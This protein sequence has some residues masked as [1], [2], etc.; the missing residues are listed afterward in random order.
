MDIFKVRG[1]RKIQGEIVLQGAKNSALPILAAC[2]AVKGECIIHNCPKLSD[3][4]AAIEILKHLG[5]RIDR[6]D[7]TICVNSLN[8]SRCDIPQNLMHKMRSSIIFLGPLLSRC[9]KASIYAPG[10]CE[11]GMRPIDLHLTAMQ[12]LGAEIMEEHGIINFECTCL[13][14]SKIVLSFPSVGATENIII[15][16]A[17]A[18]GTTQIINA[19]REPEIKDLICFLNSCGAKIKDLG[20]GEIVIEGTDNLHGTEHTVIPDRITASAFMAAAGITGGEISIKSVVPMH[21]FPVITC[22]EEA[23]CKISCGRDSLYLNAPERLNRVKTI[24]T[25]PYPG[26]PT[27]SQAIIMAMLS[28][29]KG[30]SMIVENI[31]ENRFRHVAELKKLGAKISVEGKVAVVE[32][33]KALKGARVASHDLRGGG[34]LVTA[35]LAAQGETIIENVSLIDRGW[36]NIEKDL[37]SLGADIERQKDT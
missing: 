7:N 1:Q 10:G 32:G 18:E 30:T 5:C 14:G 11:I 20:E 25:M 24:R 21:L 19:A 12:K 15:A 23:G 26:F 17:A 13:R 29:A 8:I 3:V 28:T 31:F 37:R 36:Q 27:D 34:A 35:A 6:Y 33:T 4:D 22:F 9:K 2:A 16:A